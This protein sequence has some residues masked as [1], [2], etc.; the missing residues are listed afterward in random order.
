M[1]R[2]DGG[3]GAKEGITP[4]SRARCT[5]VACT[6]GMFTGASKPAR[7]HAAWQWVSGQT[8]PHTPPRGLAARMAAA[9]RPKSEG[10]PTRTAM[11]KSAGEHAAGH[12]LRQGFVAQ[13]WHRSTS[14]RSWASVSTGRDVALMGFPREAG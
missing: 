8:S 3:A 4:S 12:A 14:A 1:R 6:A 2:S 9:A 13:Y 5:M 7:E 10:A 11:M